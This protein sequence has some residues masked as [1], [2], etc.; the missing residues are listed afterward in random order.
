MADQL[1]H[2][3]V[4]QKFRVASLQPT[5]KALVEMG[6]Q[7]GEPVQQIDRYYRHPSRDFSQTDEAFRLRT[8]GHSNCITYKGPKVDLQTKTRREEEVALADGDEARISG[9]AIFQSLGFQPVATVA[10]QRCTAKLERDEL[11]IEFA[12]DRVQSL[13][14]FVEIEIGVS[15]LDA[16][17]PVVQQARETLTLLAS[18][19]GLDEVERRSYLELLLESSKGN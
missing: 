15:A 11:T 9:D 17:D 8:V 3:E 10:K 13:G 2:F 1:Q 16:D 14:E 19:L 12:L 4:E 6:L 18:Q 7:F 5:L